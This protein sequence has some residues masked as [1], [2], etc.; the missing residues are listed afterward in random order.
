MRRS[1][2]KIVVYL[3]GILFLSIFAALFIAQNNF[4]HSECIDKHPT[5]KVVNLGLNDGFQASGNLSSYLMFQEF[6]SDVYTQDAV[7]WSY[8]DWR[9]YVI[10][11]IYGDIEVNLN[12]TIINDPLF[13][14]NID[15]FTIYVMGMYNGSLSDEDIANLKSQ[16]IHNTVDIGDISFLKKDD[17]Q[18]KLSINIEV[19]S[20]PSMWY[21][22]DHLE[23]YL[24]SENSSGRWYNESGSHYIKV[25]DTNSLELSDPINTDGKYEHHFLGPIE[26]NTSSI[27]ENVS[28]IVRV[29]YYLNFLIDEF[30]EKLELFNLFDDD[31]SS[32]EISYIY[33]GDYTDGNPGELII[34]VLDDSG[35]FVDPSGNYSVPNSLGAHNFSFYAVDDDN[36]RYDDNL[37]S[38]KEIW[39]NITDDDT[40]CPE[41]SY[42]YTG[43][44]TDGNPGELI[45]NA[46]DISGLSLDPSGTYQVPSTI[47]NHKFIFTASDADDDRLGDILNTTISIW[48]N[49]TDD[50]IICPKISY[51]YT[52]DGTDGN[53]GELIINASDVSGLSIDPSGLYQV[54]NSIG[55]HTFVFSAA[56]ADNDG[57]GDIL[58]TT[59]TIMITIIDDDDEAPIVNISII[60]NNDEAL[61]MKSFNVINNF[62]YDYQEFLII[63]ILTEDKSGISSLFIDFN[64][65]RFYDD[66][67]DNLILIE[68]PRIPGEYYFSITATDDDNDRE[69]DQKSIQ[70]IQSFEVIDD[71][72]TPPQ[73]SLSYNNFEYQ[74]SIFDNDGIVDSKATGEYHLID[75]E[76]LILDSGIIS[77]ENFY[78]IITLPLK[79]GNYTLEVYSTNNDIDWEGD[80]ESN[81]EIFDITIGIECCFQNI[82]ELLEKL[83]V[84]VDNNLYSILADSIRFKL[85]LAQ[86]DLWDALVLVEAGNIKSCVFNEALVQAIIEFVEFETEI[87]NK[88]DL[89]TEPIMN[90]IVGSLHEIRNFVVLLMGASVDY[91]TSINYGYDIA[92]L[93]VDLLNLADFV[94]E[95]LGGSGSKYL[96]KLIKLSALHLELAIMKLSRG[97]NPDS[98]L[99]SAQRFVERAIEEAH[100][101]LENNEST[102]AIICLLLETLEYCYFRISE[103]ILN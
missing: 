14:N 85:R 28:L 103:I 65:N 15:I 68:N 19:E 44:G 27:E 18:L 40:S 12:D 59:I 84:Y 61:L 37:E 4:I 94:E 47:G 73:I 86:E 41:I 33:T 69:G 25:Y 6:W 26:I 96:E 48:I 100:D 99:S 74:I 31:E 95:E 91:A 53:P 16:I 80:K 49:I 9:S 24:K 97:I 3:T 75:E 93:E 34:S 8:L 64:D 71:D 89:I 42:I 51:V 90:E 46:S 57:P 39:I 1:N 79:P 29:G 17:A 5:N 77:L 10:L 82:D 102:E 32:P 52:G 98:T 70:I 76:G 88:I 20:S 30:V 58:S 22:A 63:Q 72:I 66:D 87:Y 83:I 35:L 81:I 23:I 11:Q 92:T 7:N 13:E 2:R 50:D 36:D 45:V 60:N 54:P 38:N 43:D 67:G 101:I 78:Y 55:N 21:I 56:D 62:V